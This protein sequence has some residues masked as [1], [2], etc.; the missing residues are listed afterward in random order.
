MG[1]S[2]PCWEKGQSLSVGARA[3][4]LVMLSSAGGCSEGS[5]EL[6]FG[7]FHSPFSASVEA[8]GVSSVPAVQKEISIEGKRVPWLERSPYACP[9]PALMVPVL[10]KPFRGLI[11]S[12]SSSGGNGSPGTGAGCPSGNLH[13]G[14]RGSPCCASEVPMASVTDPCAGALQSPPTQLP[15]PGISVFLSSPGLRGQR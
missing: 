15:A 5:P 2:L 10:P 3:G 14:A 12:R 11:C 1:S 8:E 9:A 7:C 4:G 6:F 13:A